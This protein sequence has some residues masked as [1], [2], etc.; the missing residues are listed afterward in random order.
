MSTRIHDCSSPDNI[1]RPA[2]LTPKIESDFAEVAQSIKAACDTY[3]QEVAIAA[4]YLAQQ[5][6]FEPGH[7]IDDWLAAEAQNR[8]A[9]RRRVLG[10]SVSAADPVA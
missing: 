1:F 7:E 2:M 4:Y 3:N 9:R 6:G 5:R 8:M 10:P